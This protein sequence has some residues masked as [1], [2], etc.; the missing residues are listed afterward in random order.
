MQDFEVESYTN[1]GITKQILGC[2]SRLL[3][4]LVA[5]ANRDELRLH[6]SSLYER[7]DRL[8]HVL[9]LKWS[10]GFRGIYFGIDRGFR[11]ELWDL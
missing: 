10:E 7:Q 4:A 5:L 9:G 2:D 3:P 1:V 11:E 6:D 8:P